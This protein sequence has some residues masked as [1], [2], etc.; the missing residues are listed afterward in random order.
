MPAPILVWN[1]TS[2]RE[3]KLVGRE[4]AQLG[5]E[6]EIENRWEL[7]KPMSSQWL[8]FNGQSTELHED[9]QKF[10]QPK[11]AAEPAIVIC[12]SR[13]GTASA[14]SDLISRR[15]RQ[16]AIMHR[17]AGLMFNFFQKTFREEDEDVVEFGDKKSLESALA[18]RTRKP[19]IIE[20]T[21]NQ[22]GERRL[23]FGK[24]K[25]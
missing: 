18:V 8:D 15:W 23:N 2:E 25:L 19:K 4:L 5:W 24:D 6:N 17:R 16:T 21:G 22:L 20:D 10:L 3:A 7:G 11:L 12:V 9:L 13:G 14:V 1:I